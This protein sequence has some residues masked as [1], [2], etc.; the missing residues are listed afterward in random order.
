MGKYEDRRAL[1]NEVQKRPTQGWFRIVST[2]GKSGSGYRLGGEEVTVPSETE[3]STEGAGNCF[4]K[5]VQTP[6]DCLTIS[7]VFNCGKQ[8][9]YTQKSKIK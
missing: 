7:N 4:L 9:I 2:R 1:G 8:A 3:A 5:M 6:Q